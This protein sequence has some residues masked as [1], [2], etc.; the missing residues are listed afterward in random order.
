[1][2]ITDKIKLLELNYN[3]ISNQ[4]SLFKEAKPYDEEE[5]K[6]LVNKR[7]ILLSELSTLRKTKWELDHSY[8]EFDDDR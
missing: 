1:M 4:L 2:A 8:V 7:N 5:I 3:E 6:R